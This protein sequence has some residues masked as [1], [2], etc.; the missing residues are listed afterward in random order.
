MIRG[1]GK[2]NFFSKGVKNTKTWSK[3]VDVNFVLIGGKGRGVFEG[4]DRASSQE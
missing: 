1:R 3:I 2:R 4:D